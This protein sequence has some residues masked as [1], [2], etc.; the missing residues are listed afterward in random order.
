MTSNRFFKQTLY[1]L[2][3][4]IASALLSV[5]PVRAATADFSNEPHV[6]VLVTVDGHIVL[7][8]KPTT[9]EETERAID[10]LFERHGVFWY[11]RANGDQPP[12]A[13]QE[14]LFESLFDYVMKYRLPIRLFTDG[15]FTKLV[16]M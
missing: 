15:T 7:D 6:A 11:A 14:R 16:Q 8:G 9:L 1:L 12:S 5:T 4:T 10:D 3:A 13:S 2:I